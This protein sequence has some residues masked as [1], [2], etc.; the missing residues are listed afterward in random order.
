MLAGD[1]AG[2]AT[3]TITAQ[4]SETHQTINSQITITV[5]PPAQLPPASVNL[6]QGSGGL[7]VNGSNGP[8]A[9]LLTAQV[10]DIAGNPI[11]NPPSG[12]NNVRFQIS[13]AGSDAILYGLDATGKLVSG[14]SIDTSTYGGLANV[15]ILAGSVQGP[16]QVSA[17]TDAADGNVSNGIGKP[18]SAQTTVIVSDGRLYS[19]NDRFANR[20]RHSVRN[21]ITTVVESLVS[22]ARRRRFR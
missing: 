10:I 9:K 8:G 18:I 3:L 14:S 20:Q 21:G 15:S 16:V 7:Y 19:L 12:V 13:P 1:Q 5:L 17:T 22:A 6:S 11:T 2:T 4:D